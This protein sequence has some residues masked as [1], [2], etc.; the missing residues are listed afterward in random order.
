MSGNRFN[1]IEAAQKGYA[2]A[3]KERGYLARAALLPMGAS[4]IFGMFLGRYVPDPKT[5]P[6]WMTG[7][8]FFLPTDALMGWYIFL[9]ARLAL[10]GEKLE[11]VPRD[12]RAMAGWKNLRNGCVLSYMLIKVAL[13]GLQAVM[14]YTATVRPPTAGMAVLAMF[15]IGAFFWGVRFIAAP[16]LLAVGYPVRAYIFRVNGIGISLRVVGLVFLGIL[17]VMLAAMIIGGLF[18]P[19]HLQGMNTQIKIMMALGPVADYVFYTLFMGALCFGL[20]DM[21]SPPRRRRSS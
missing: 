14:I 19:D 3:W 15:S 1:T 7:N 16:L 2:F 13:I 21:L 10:L 18:L 11:A 17:P 9:L 5:V 12:P 20:K 8:L 6:E 4:I